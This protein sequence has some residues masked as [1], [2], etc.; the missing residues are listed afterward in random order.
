MIKRTI[1]ASIVLQILDLANQLKKK[2]DII[3]QQLGITTQQ[4]L[5][6]LHLANDPNIPYLNRTKHLKKMMA[7]E[8][9]ESLN[10][11]RANI[12][13]LLTTLMQKN[14]IIQ[15]EDET[16]RRIKRLALTEQGQAIVDTIESSRHIHNSKFL[17]HF[18]D[19]EKEQFFNSLRECADQLHGFSA[20]MA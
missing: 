3:C 9:A 1:E 20:P 10:V 19:F 4:W 18:S 7:S 5:I 6:L 15:I 16:D 13:N 11:S 14:L 8:L 12:T 2:G 17:E